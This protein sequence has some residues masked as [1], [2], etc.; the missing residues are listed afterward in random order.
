MVVR[1]DPGFGSQD[2]DVAHKSSASNRFRLVIMVRVLAAAGVDIAMPS[3]A[4]TVDRRGESR[5]GGIAV[6]MPLGDSAVLAL[7]VVLEL[8]AAGDDQSFA[9]PPGA[10][11][12]NKRK[13]LLLAG[14][15][16][17]GAAKKSES[18][19]GVAHPLEFYHIGERKQF[20]VHGP[21]I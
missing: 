4:A 11:R 16:Q 17:V 18:D 5:G 21:V 14:E 6:P 7:W 15:R 1:A 19:L 2:D 8:G 3:A 12:T 10:A 20:N 9:A 13:G